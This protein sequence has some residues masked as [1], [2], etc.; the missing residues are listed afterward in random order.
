[1]GSQG[2][3][4]L[5][6]EESTTEGAGVATTKERRSVCMGRNYLLCIYLSYI[7]LEKL[8]H[9]SPSR[10][11]PVHPLTLQHRLL[12]QDPSPSQ[13]RVITTVHV[14]WLW[15]CNWHH[16][17]CAYLSTTITRCIH[18]YMRIWIQHVPKA[19]VL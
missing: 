17:T 15:H 8:R 10:S 12:P 5:H 4:M 7:L 18:Y 11:Y 1:M 16:R 9:S 13:Y 14:L 19:I 2:E 6:V 3:I